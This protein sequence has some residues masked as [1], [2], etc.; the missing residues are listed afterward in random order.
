M[1]FVTWLFFVKWLFFL[2]QVARLK[3]EGLHQLYGEHQEVSPARVL[4]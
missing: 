1:L 2:G 3:P 4:Q